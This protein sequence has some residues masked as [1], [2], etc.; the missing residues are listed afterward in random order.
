MITENSLEE[1]AEH[2]CALEPATRKVIPA[3]GTLQGKNKAGAGEGH[4]IGPRGQ[5]LWRSPGA[6]SIYWGKGS[7]SFALRDS[8]CE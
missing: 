6:I 2:L 8:L 3:A 5:V 1:S 4:D 7:G